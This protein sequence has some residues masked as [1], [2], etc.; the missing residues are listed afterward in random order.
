MISGFKKPA[1]RS[2]CRR[3]QTAEICGVSF[4]PF[5][6]DLIVILFHSFEHI[7]R[8]YAHGH[9]IV[10]ATTIRIALFG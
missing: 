3:G 8:L 9:V 5:L 10:G 4:L 2:G 1:A 6:S 7:W